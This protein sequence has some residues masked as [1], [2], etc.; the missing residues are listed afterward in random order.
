[1]WLCLMSLFLYVNQSNLKNSKKIFLNNEITS[2]TNSLN[3]S[4]KLNAFLKENANIAKPYINA[5]K[6]KTN[7]KLLFVDRY[8]KPIRYL[9]SSED[10][11]SFRNNESEIFDLISRFTAKSEEEIHSVNVKNDVYILASLL[12]VQDTKA[13]I[14]LFK[15]NINDIDFNESNNIGIISAISLLLLILFGIITLLNESI[16]NNRLKAIKNS[17]TVL[18]SSGTNEAIKL[19][20]YDSIASKINAIKTKIESI[21]ANKSSFVSNVSHEL[22]S[23][24][25]NIKGF[26]QLLIDIKLDEKTQNEYL[27]II[28]NEI[29]R[30][31][32]LIDSLIKLSKLD[33]NNVAPHFEAFEL[34]EL[35]RQAIIPFINRIEEKSLNLED[36]ICNDKLVVFAD[37]RQILQAISNLIDN[38]IKYTQNNGKIIIETTKLNKKAVFSIKDNGIGISN[39]DLEHIFERFYTVSKSRTDSSTGLG[40]SICK[41]ILEMHGEQIKVKS[42]LSK[43]TEFEFELNLYEVKSEK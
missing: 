38:A 36:C 23:P 35:I 39:E 2:L 7:S 25:T 28:M 24:I 6:N 21:E 15:S 1:M 5:F 42:Q 30:I 29:N 14:I 20:I 17:L 40:L 32:A 10:M 18:N 26:V 13:G 43:G 8:G 16:R 3:T 12:N 11:S 31:S 41:K 37:K 9:N 22:K 4:L 27:N 34:N 19:D 33:E